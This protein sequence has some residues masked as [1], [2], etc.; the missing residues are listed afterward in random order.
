MTTN[1]ERRALVSLIHQAMWQ[2]G[3]DHSDCTGNDD[4][5]AAADAIIAAGWWPPLADLGDRL[6]RI[7]EVLSWVD[8]LQL[9]EHVRA[10]YEALVADG[11]EDTRT[12]A[13][14]EAL[15]QRDAFRVQLKALG[16][17]N[18]RLREQ[19]G[20]IYITPGFTATSVTATCCCGAVLTDS[21]TTSLAAMLGRHVTEARREQVQS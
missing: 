21:G 4:D 12:E 14:R 2:D 7:V 13:L 10:E 9:P 18:A 19:H 20:I 5:R 16:A 8:P 1:I 15:R 3:D 6:R 17:E 11:G